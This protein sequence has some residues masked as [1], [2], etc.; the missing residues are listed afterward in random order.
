MGFVLTIIF[1]VIVGAIVLLGWHSVD[2]LVGVSTLTEAKA[3]GLLG[4]FAVVGAI[5]GGVLT[6][7]FD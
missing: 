1:S 4:I 5:T 6:V 7:L 3:E 2:L